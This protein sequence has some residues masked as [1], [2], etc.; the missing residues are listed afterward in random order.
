M[1]KRRD[2]AKLVG[3]IAACQ[4]AGAIG[5]YFTAPQIDTWYA[6][7]AKPAFTPPNA[8]FMPVWLTLYTLMAIAVFLIW[9]QGVRE[10]K[11]KQAFVL[12]WIQ[13]GINA[14][15]SVVFF[16]FQSI[17][18]GF[19]I[20]VCLWVMVLVTMLRFFKISLPAGVL[21]TPYLA[22]LSIASSLNAWLWVL[23]G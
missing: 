23:N 14:V 20:I 15:W 13:L 19:V 3:S 11:N 22:W 9:R 2:I 5:S 6:T 4:G 1:M 16:G 12:F 18:G 8:V 10:G 17:L 7:L 21:L